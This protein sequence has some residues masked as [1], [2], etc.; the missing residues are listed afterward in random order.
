MA[1]TLDDIK[2]LLE[3]QL[4]AQTAGGRGK[5]SPTGTDATG[6][7][8]VSTEE[9][10][11]ANP[12]ITALREEIQALRAEMS[13][14]ETTSEEFAEAQKKLI[15][16]T[17]EYNSQ[18]DATTAALNKQSK[19][20]SKLTGALR[21]IAD[22]VVGISSK[23][24]DVQSFARE[25]ERT[26]ATTQAV[27]RQAIRLAD[28]L[29]L[30]GVSYEEATQAAK[31]LTA[32][33][34]DFTMMSKEMQNSLITDASLFNEVGIS[35]ETYSKNLQIG[36]K[37]MGMTAEE[38]AKNMRDIRKTALALNVPVTQLMDDFAG[39]E[40]KLAQL[41]DT[42]TTSFKEMAR[43]QKITGLEMGKLI[44]MTD[45]FDTFEGAAEAAGSLN[46]A[47]GGNFVDSMSL[48][49]E[50]DPAERFKMIR[51]AIDSSGQSIEGM[52]RKQKMFMAGQLD[53]NVADFTKAMSGDLSVLEDSSESAADAAGNQIKS[54][55]DSAT[56][57]RSQTELAANFAKSLEPAYGILGDKAMEVT[58]RYSASMFEVAQ[59]ANEAQKALAN[60]T[61]P[62][63]AAALG[64][65]ESISTGWEKFSG[66]IGALVT[67]LIGPLFKG[68]W[69][70]GKALGGFFKN[71]GKGGKNAS[72]TMKNLAKSK[73]NL[74]KSSK[75]IN[76]KTG[77]IATPK[78]LKNIKAMSKSTQ[79][80]SKGLGNAAKNAGNATK[81]LSAAGKAAPNLAKAGGKLGA[82]GTLARLGGMG[83][84]AI[85]SV[86]NMAYESIK[87]VKKAMDTEGADLKDKAGAAMIGMGHGAAE[88]LDFV[89]FGLVDKVS[90]MTSKTGKSFTEAFE[91]LDYGGIG[92]AFQYGF[93]DGVIDG[94]L[95][96]LGIRS[97]STVMMGIGKDMLAGLML[98]MEDG[99]DA[100]FESAKGLIDAFIEPWKSIGELLMEII[101]PALELVPDSIKNI[102]MGDTTATATNLQA[103][104]G[105]V[106]TAIT[107]A[108]NAATETGQ[109]QVINISL[110]LDGKEIDKKVIN[111]LG[112]V[113]KE[114]VL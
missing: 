85:A 15:E 27:S 102:F 40:E 76:A 84:T 37:A 39:T 82:K 34:T 74:S 89:T 113:V 88:A 104:A 108:K 55:E 20:S 41:G 67:T 66:L 44:A 56:L 107:N 68:L 33:T 60:M 78:N 26:G 28:D 114:A 92:E 53:M 12:K 47:L 111:L 17:K 51:D 32:Q 25:L 83:A 58:D 49:M 79:D 65:V 93:K 91:E 54:L 109:A 75:L 30:S 81:T 100:L 52:T 9:V 45:K 59:W 18:V 96:L 72:K 71:F 3:K 86:G 13:G 4:K 43:I 10:E 14:M 23:L 8:K 95:Q 21:E 110:T 90:Q 11:K 42:G 19:A 112:G 69:K 98:P 24:N 105:P 80:L 5:A 70:G 48:M 99:V 101:Q 61:P 77:Q 1:A 62:E 16:Q 22:G 46:A 7:V 64:Q 94:T 103:A 73:A 6:N 50:D 31:A 38:S 97:P 87:A 29:R 35:T 106:E 63:L 36:I 57:I 2:E